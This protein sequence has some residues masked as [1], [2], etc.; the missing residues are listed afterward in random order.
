VSYGDTF[1]KLEVVVPRKTETTSFNLLQEHP[2]M[3]KFKKATTREEYFECQEK[4]RDWNQDRAL[5][6][7]FVVAT[8]EA[9]KRI[10]KGGTIQL[11]VV[12]WQHADSIVVCHQA[13]N[14]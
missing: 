9:C 5:R 6:S 12:D 8:W 3:A 13:S 2:L 14:K 10:Q 7:L 1:N 4:F 11:P